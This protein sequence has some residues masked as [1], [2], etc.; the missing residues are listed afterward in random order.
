MPG[1]ILEQILLETMQRHMEAKEVIG[2]S[3]CGFIKG[4]SYA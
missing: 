1:K 2:D 4:K 3:Q